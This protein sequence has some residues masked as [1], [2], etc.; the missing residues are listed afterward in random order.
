MSIL[1]YPKQLDNSI[2]DYIT[3]QHME[4]RSN[5]DVGATGTREG[6]TGLRATAPAGGRGGGGRPPAAAGSNQIILYMPS[7]TP[8]TGNGN[9]WGREN[10]AGAL[11]EL[12][13]NTLMDA[14]SLVD[15]ITD[16]GIGA[17]AKD[18]WDGIVK[19]GKG[20]IDQKG[21]AA[22]QL[23]VEFIAQVGGTQAN[24]LMALNKGE[25]YNPNVEM[26]YRGPAI[27]GFTFNFEFIPKSQ[28]EAEIINNIIMEFKLF[29][30]PADSGNG[31]Y[32][33]PDVWAVNYCSGAS[34]NKNMNVFKE[35]ACKNVAVQTNRDVPSYMSFENGM[36]IQTSLSLEFTEVDVI[37][38]D[39]Q[40]R[41]RDRGSM[42]G[43]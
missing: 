5:M 12:K 6:R 43:F 21:A 30:A 3:F 35:M 13:R 38:R 37:T 16:Q 15:N 11:G 23:G 29:S 26:L 2:V 17:T 22:K 40:E 9:D 41:A 1:K 27:R 20:L 42:V 36:P 10:F 31:M 39:D 14:A 28:D 24:T 4:Y 25:I 7:N 33:V 19:A 34:Q 32:K 8:P 18:A